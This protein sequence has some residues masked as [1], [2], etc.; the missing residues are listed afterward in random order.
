MSVGEA[1]DPQRSWWEGPYHPPTHTHM[2]THTY[3]HTY[4]HIHRHTHTYIHTHIYIHRHIHTHTQ[5]DRHPPPFC[6]L[7]SPALA[8][9]RAYLHFA[10]GYRTS[11]VGQG[12]GS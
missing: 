6:F 9:S 4:T 12:L 7:L 10:P 1:K 8:M 2:H 3:T 5:R 11:H